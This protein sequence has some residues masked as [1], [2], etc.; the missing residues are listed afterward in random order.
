MKTG[1]YILITAAKNEEAYIGEA[2]RSVL[3]Q[4]ALP[5]AWFIMDDGSTDRT[6]EIISEAAARHAFIHLHSSG[7]KEG[8]NFGSQYKAI[9]AGYDLARPLEF[10]FL[11]VQDADIALTRDDYY[12]TMI[13]KFGHNA[14]LGIVG[15]Y[16]HERL[17]GQWRCRKGNSEDAVAGGIQMFRRACFEHVGGYTPL[18]LGGS[19]WLAQIDARMAG[20]EVFACPDFPALHYRPTSS[21]NGSL[22]GWIQLG[23]LDASFGSHPLFEIFKCARRCS[24]RPLVI[25]G[26]LR[27]A[28]FLWWRACY[29]KPL[30]PPEKVAFLRRSQMGKIARITSR[31][32]PGKPGDPASVTLGS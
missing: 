28:G 9:Q 19:D 23:L 1:A 22:R 26:V 3:R 13:A 24:C 15:G 5:K 6:A 18:Q 8:R 14:R 21:A 27:L 20:W 17:D 7:A 2:L 30:I 4:S 12:E 16:I 25:G 10:E 32:I 11:G 31:L 29:R